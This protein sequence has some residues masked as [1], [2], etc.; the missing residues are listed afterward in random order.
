MPLDQPWHSSR[1][2]LLHIGQNPHIVLRPIYYL[3]PEP[4]LKVL[5]PIQSCE[6]YYNTYRTLDSGHCPYHLRPFWYCGHLVCSS[7][8]CFCIIPI[9]QLGSFRTE[10]LFGCAT[11]GFDPFRSIST[12]DSI[13]IYSLPF[14]Q[15]WL[16]EERLNLLPWIYCCVQ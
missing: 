10:S 9:C 2:T 15:W 3:K 1:L 12:W 14:A 5:Q 16:S 13:H 8:A 11:L 4:S 7:K 6:C